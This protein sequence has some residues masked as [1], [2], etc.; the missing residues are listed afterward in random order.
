MNLQGN[1]RRSTPEQ[2]IIFNQN[3]SDLSFNSNENQ[4]DTPYFH[5]PIAFNK[6]NISS[7]LK[8]RTIIDKIFSE[9]KHKIPMRNGKMQK[10][11]ENKSWDLSFVDSS[12][13]NKNTTINSN[14][15]IESSNKPRN[16]VKFI[17]KPD[18]K[19]KT[20][21]NDDY[22]IKARLQLQKQNLKLNLEKPKKKMFNISKVNKNN[23]SHISNSSFLTLS[24]QNSKKY[25][26][27]SVDKIRKPN[28]KIKRNFDITP[29]VKRSNSIDINKIKCSDGSH[30]HILSFANSI[31]NDKSNDKISFLSY[32]R[33]MTLISKSEEDKRIVFMFI[34]SNAYSTFGIEN[35]EIK[36]VHSQSRKILY[37]FNILSIQFCEVSKKND[38]V[39]K[40]I[41]NTKDYNEEYYLFC[42]S[43]IEA[44]TFVTAL[45][46]AVNVSKCKAF[47]FTEK[48]GVGK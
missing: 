34:P 11:E 48:F 31:N 21:N 28:I 41:V 13:S 18:A 45:N 42:N 40:I 30:L 9:P 15:N 19:F 20:I 26:T 16:V 12:F 46:F 7:V 27:I 43:A 35:Y 37:S 39:I 2:E 36:L 23:F 8:R 6:T 38:K 1:S 3:I 44:K 17:N 29:S 4:P 14:N 22:S 32:P 5:A 24:S 33:M 25:N 10:K 47:T